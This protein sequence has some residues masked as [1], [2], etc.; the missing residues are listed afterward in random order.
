[1]ATV[2]RSQRVKHDWVTN[3]FTFTFYLSPK[4]VYAGQEVTV[5]TRS[6]T[7][8]GSKLGKEF[9]KAVSCHPAYLTYVQKCW[10]G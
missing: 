2:Y 1:M 3:T 4:K 6:G 7:K 5:R 8:T 10:A 9:I